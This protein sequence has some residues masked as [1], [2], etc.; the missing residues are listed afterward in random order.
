MTSTGR[1][2]AQETSGNSSCSEAFCRTDSSNIATGRLMMRWVYWEPDT[3]LL[4]EKR[5]DCSQCS[6]RGNSVPDVATEG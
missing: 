1:F 3:K 6:A 4:D 2:D 5:E